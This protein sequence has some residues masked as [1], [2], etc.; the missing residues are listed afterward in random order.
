MALRGALTK[1]QAGLVI[2]SSVSEQ[3]NSKHMTVRLGSYYHFNKQTGLV[4]TSVSD[5]HS[6]GGN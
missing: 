6:K 1:S 2:F 5:Y 4:Y 3:K